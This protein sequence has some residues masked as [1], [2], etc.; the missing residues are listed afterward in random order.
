MES[1]S[2]GQEAKTRDARHGRD[3]IQKMVENGEKAG[4]VR[5]VEEGSK[6]RTGQNSKDRRALMEMSFQARSIEGAGTR[7]CEFEL[8]RRSLDMSSAI[9]SCDAPCPESLDSTKR[10]ETGG[11]K[12]VAES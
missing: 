9:S 1:H 3:S 10:K 4:P 6:E 12:V 11:G 8:V 2:D 7:L 5:V